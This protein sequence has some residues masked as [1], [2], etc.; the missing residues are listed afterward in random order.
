ME[1]KSVRV[2]VMLN[3][4]LLDEIDKLAGKS[5]MSRS[6]IINRALSVY[7]AIHRELVKYL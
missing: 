1:T 4:E 2:A 6:Q 7:L 5:Q 3:K